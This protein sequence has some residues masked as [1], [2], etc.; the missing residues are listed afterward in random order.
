MRVILSGTNPAPM[1]ITPSSETP[2]MN[3]YSIES[4]DGN[5]DGH[6]K[7]RTGVV[8]VANPAAL[9]DSVSGEVYNCWG[10]TYNKEERGKCELEGADD[11]RRFALSHAEVLDEGGDGRE[12]GGIVE[13]I[14]ELCETEDN[15]EHIT[16]RK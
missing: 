14:E 3:A 11:P 12:Q 4:S 10:G 1:E 5:G 8:H 16:P 15:E 9:R 13:R 2:M 6:C 7:R